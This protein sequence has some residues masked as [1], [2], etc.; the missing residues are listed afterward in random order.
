MSITKYR[1][2]I[3]AAAVVALVFVFAAFSFQDGKTAPPKCLGVDMLAEMS[4]R[5]PAAYKTVMD[6]AGALP[7]SEA[8]LWKIEKPGVDP[9]YLLGT[10]HLS[11]PRI[12]RLSPATKDAIGHSTSVALEVADLSDK[13]VAEAMAKAS[14]LL[15]YSDG[16]KLD[17]RLSPEEFK[18]VQQVVSKSGLPDSASTLMKPWLVSMLMATSDC[19]RKQVASGAKV[20]DL[21]VGAEAERRG[22]KVVGLE[23]IQD[24][25]GAMASIPDDEQVAMLKVGLQYIDR[26]NDLMETLVQMYLNRKI[27]AAMPFQIALAAE[28]GTPASAFDGFQKALLVDRNARMAEAALP[29]LDKGKAFIGIGAL[30]LSG[31]KGLVALLREQGFTVTAVE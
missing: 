27:S 14:A 2:E 11:D 20:L 8:V 19:E 24:Q 22:I 28:H 26:S 16:T 31:P 12:A 7:N 21:L 29:L 9:S 15:V 17:T 4:E 5:A 6:E 1:T 13:A 18:K 30:H 3:A 10:M 25:L 23:T